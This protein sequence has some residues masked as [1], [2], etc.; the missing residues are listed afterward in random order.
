M[1]FAMEVRAREQARERLRESCRQATGVDQA[2]GRRRPRREHRGQ[3]I[4]AEAQR[5]GLLG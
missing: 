2:S 5:R 4:E 1:D 3:L